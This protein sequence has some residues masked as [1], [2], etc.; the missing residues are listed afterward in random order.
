[1]FDVSN[2]LLQIIC[3]ELN[4][5]LT[6]LNELLYSAGKVLQGKCGM[7]LQ[8]KK[9]ENT[10]HEKAKLAVKDRKGNRN[11]SKRNLFVSGTS[12]G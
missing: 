6:F 3:N 12:K 1:M 2:K 8:R 7:K 9:E 4:P 10:W 5:V 11:I